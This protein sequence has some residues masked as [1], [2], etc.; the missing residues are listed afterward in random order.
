MTIM[1]YDIND[2]EVN[3]VITQGRILTFVIILSFI[4]AG[5]LWGNV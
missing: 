5:I 4:I 1:E 2:K 3:K